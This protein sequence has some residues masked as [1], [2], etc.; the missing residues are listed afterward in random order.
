M[1]KILVTL[2]VLVMS[3]SVY[4]FP[5]V[6]EGARELELDF[7][8]RDSD[9]TLGIGYGVFIT[10][11][12]LVGGKLDYNDAADIWRLGGKMEYH[13]NMGTMTVPYVAAVVAYEDYNID[14]RFLYGPAVGI[15]HFITDYLAID[16]R[17]EYLLSS[18]DWWEEELEITAGLRVLF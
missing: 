10:D 13:W 14:T 15:K 6:Q 9:W 7:L 12:I 5:M 18:E 8:F 2:M 3:A 11:A 4:A 16:M 1:K 17:A